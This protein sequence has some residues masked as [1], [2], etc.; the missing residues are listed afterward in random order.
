MCIIKPN[1]VADEWKHN[2]LL[3]INARPLLK[4]AISVMLG[5]VETELCTLI[6]VWN[7]LAEK[8]KK[9]KLQMKTGAA[10]APHTC[11]SWL[12]G[13]LNLTTTAENICRSRSQECERRIVLC[14]DHTLMLAVQW[15]ALGH[16]C[17]HC[18]RPPTGATTPPPRPP[19]SLIHSK[20]QNQK[21]II[22]AMRHLWFCTPTVSSPDSKENI[23]QD[24]FGLVFMSSE[25]ERGCSS[26]PA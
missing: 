16:I 7:F 20:S 24:Q 18:L 14:G 10:T 3:C 23:P 4:T 13:G 15:A 21:H 1:H 12:R 6:T 17:R 22:P 25:L 26:D 2:Q 5:P 9:K 19:P 8:K 11:V